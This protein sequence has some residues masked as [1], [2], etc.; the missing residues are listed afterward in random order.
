MGLMM[1]S[2]P[3]EVLNNLDSEENLLAVSMDQPSTSAQH[4]VQHPLLSMYQP[5]SV[6]S[7][8]A[9]S[10]SMGAYSVNLVVPEGTDTD[11]YKIAV[12]A[13]VLDG[14]C[15]RNQ[16]VSPKIAYSRSKLRGYPSR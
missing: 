5:S 10:V 13:G 12:L 7:V 14:R 6:S 3:Q 4:Q 1:S 11:I 2:L 9:P 16:F 8:S 15:F